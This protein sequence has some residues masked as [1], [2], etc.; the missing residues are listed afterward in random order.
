MGDGHGGGEAI[1][2]RDSGYYAIDSLR[3]E[4]GYRAWGHEL[5]VSDTPL[6]A[7]LSFTVD[8]AKGD[9]LGRDALLALEGA[10]A[11]TSRLV[12]LHIADEATPLWGSEPI[13][14]N[15]TVVGNITSAGSCAFRRRPGGDLL[16]QPSR[17]RDKGIR[18][19]RSTIS[20]RAARSS[21]RWPRSGRSSTQSGACTATIRSTFVR[22]FTHNTQPL[23]N[24]SG[25]GSS[26]ITLITPRVIAAIVNTLTRY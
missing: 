20:M 18:K 26:P 6:D 19:G 2:L 4:A 10:G 22:K 7:G 5:G 21:T 25:T 24:H 16:R 12:I 9:F 14:R 11:R 17:R 23:L 3:L 13:L 8:W 1:D 15:G